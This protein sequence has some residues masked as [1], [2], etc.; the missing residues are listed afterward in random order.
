MYRAMWLKALA[1]TRSHRLQSALIL[2]IL[3]AASA[4]LSLSLVVQQN[5]DKP[6]RTAFERAN[7][8]HLVFFADGTAT[9]L[10]PITE[11]AEITDAAL[12]THGQKFETRVF[13][14]WKSLV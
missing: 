5:A 2:V 13:A 6:W 12:I 14:C 3:I 1:D 8:A 9:D 10:A 11:R 7:G 4:A